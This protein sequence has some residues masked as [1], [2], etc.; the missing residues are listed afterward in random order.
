MPTLTT[1]SLTANAPFATNTLH[2]SEVEIEAATVKTSSLGYALL[3]LLAVNVF[4]LAAAISFV[5]LYLRQ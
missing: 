2:R 5:W 4:V 3:T 1:L